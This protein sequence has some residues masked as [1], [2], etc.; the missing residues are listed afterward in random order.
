MQQMHGIIPCMFDCWADQVVHLL[1]A[2]SSRAKV[3]ER[4]T[5]HTGAASQYNRATE[6]CADDLTSD[7]TQPKIKP[8]FLC[9]LQCQM[10]LGQTVHLNL[11]VYGRPINK[12]F[13]I[14]L[15]SGEFLTSEDPK[16][17]FDLLARVILGPLKASVVQ[18]LVARNFA[19]GQLKP[20]T[21]TTSKRYLR[22]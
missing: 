6:R 12:L 20:F 11:C 21:V 14:R 4:P 5:G 7:Q 2:T 1:I 9:M 18:T 8:T 13:K 10:Q 3:K 22:E 16:S 17:T 19:S 15:T